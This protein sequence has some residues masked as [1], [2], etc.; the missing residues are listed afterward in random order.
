MNSRKRFT[1][2]QIAENLWVWAT[3]T[4]GGWRKVKTEDEAIVA[5]NKYYADHTIRF[6]PSLVGVYK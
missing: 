4:S 5:H 1:V 2:V 3:P 6:L